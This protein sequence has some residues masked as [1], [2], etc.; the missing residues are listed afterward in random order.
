MTVTKYYG[1][2]VMY[3]DDIQDMGHYSLVCD[4]GGFDH[5]AAK[6]ICR[7]QGYDYAATVCCS[8]LCPRDLIGSYPLYI[9]NVKCTGDESRLV[10]CQF[11]TGHDSCVTG[12]Y[13]TVVCADA[14]EI[15][16]APNGM[17][18]FLSKLL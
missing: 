16:V 5:L 8:A 11:T 17:F 6:V 14:H 4:D 18:L 3:N 13:V 1:P 7:E 10:D 15:P 2:V 12:D 9:S